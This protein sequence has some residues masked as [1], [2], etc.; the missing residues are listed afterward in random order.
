MQSNH[1]EPL[2]LGT[3]RLISINELVDLVASMRREDGEEA[4]QPHGA[5]G[6]ARAELATT[7]SCARSWAGS[8][9]CR[10]K[11]AF[12][13]R[14]SGLPPNSRPAPRRRP[15]H[16]AHRPLLRFVNQHYAPDVASTG[17]HLTDLAEFLS[18]A[19]VPVEVVTGRAHYAG[20]ALDA[21]ASEVRAGVRVRRYRTAGLGR[22]SRAGRIFDYLVFYGQVAW[23]SWAGDAVDGTVYLT[24]PPLL[25]VIGWIGKAAEGGGMGSG[26]WIYIPTPKS[27][28]GCCNAAV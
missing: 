10:S 7:R 11:T 6:R 2:N 17:Q 14:T 16:R 8:R 26:R 27:P 3:D 1:R 20:G 4:V 19:G 23:T 18:A 25:G 28:R 22:R 15:L 5:A 21:P 12:G 24:T 13:G 9:P